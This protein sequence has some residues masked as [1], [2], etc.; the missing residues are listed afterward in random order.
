MKGV[1][2]WDRDT[3]VHMHSIG[4]NTSHS[5][6]LLSIVTDLYSS[7]AFSSICRESRILWQRSLDTSVSFLDRR[8]SKNHDKDFL[9]ERD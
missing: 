6:N 8:R 4:D 3:T 1:C 9:W 2:T 7:S 5:L